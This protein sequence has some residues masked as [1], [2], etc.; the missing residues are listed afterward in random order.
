MILPGCQFLLTPAHLCT[1][2]LFPQS[3][4]GKA[5]DYMTY[6]GF[7]LMNDLPA[8]HS[9]LKR[10]KSVLEGLCNMVRFN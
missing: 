2:L 7:L 4:S 6:F 9:A 8:Q 1:A 10:L 3:F 5:F